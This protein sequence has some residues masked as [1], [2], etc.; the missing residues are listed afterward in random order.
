MRRSRPTAGDVPDR[1]LRVAMVSYYLPSDSKIGVGYM[2]HGLAEAVARLGHD[3]T[4]FS[5]CASVEGAGYRH[6]QVPLSGPLR[7]FRWGAAVARLDLRGFDVVHCHGD[8][9][10]RLPWRS[11]PVVRTMHGSCFVEA[12]HIRGLRERLRMI[13]LGVVEVVGSATARKNVAVSKATRRVYP[14]IRTVIPNGVDLGNFEPGPKSSD[15]T[16]LFVGTYEQR[17]RGRLLMEAFQR[18]VLP[19]FP[20]ARLWMVCSDAPSAPGVEV[21]GRLDAEELASRYR[22]AW[23]FCLPSSYEGFGVPY[24]EALASGTAVVA[25]PNPGALEVLRGGHL[26]VITEADGLGDALRELFADSASRRRLETAGP[27]AA[28]EYDWDVVAAEYVAI[29]RR[30]AESTS[31]R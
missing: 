22:R 12:M 6:V 8:N 28:R 23:V 15:P 4:M 5:P 26:G 18:D 17:K 31:S 1:P 2:A 7:T 30:S 29:Y 9:H 25:T 14:W 21:L 13:A 3:V 19:A 16:I 10:L 20:D 11:P 27:I 24:I